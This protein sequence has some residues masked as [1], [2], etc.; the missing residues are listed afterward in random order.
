MRLCSGV[1]VEIGIDDESGV[2]RVKGDSDVLEGE[3]PGIG[4]SVLRLFEYRG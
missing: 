1:A 4:S 2:W 3:C